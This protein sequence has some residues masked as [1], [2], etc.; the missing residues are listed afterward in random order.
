MKN[1]IYL[2]TFLCA[3][4]AT[5]Q[6]AIGKNSVSNASVS[7]EFAEEPKGQ[8]FGNFNGKFVYNFKWD[9]KTDKINITDSFKE[10]GVETGQKGFFKN[11]FLVNTYPSSEEINSH[12]YVRD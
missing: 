6:V 1:L 3:G 2:T 7:L 9:K 12:L 8:H 5:A 10:L 4:L 11:I